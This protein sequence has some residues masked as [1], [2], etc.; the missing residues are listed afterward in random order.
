MKR[1]FAWVASTRD[2]Q[3]ASCLTVEPSHT[4]T[5]T[6]T[7]RHRHIHMQTHMFLSQFSLSAVNQMLSSVSL[8]LIFALSSFIKNL[9][10]Q[11]GSAEF[12]S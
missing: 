11:R 7:G 5:Y 10:V 4:N 2:P 9:H 12:I 1:D 6:N 8:M 3:H